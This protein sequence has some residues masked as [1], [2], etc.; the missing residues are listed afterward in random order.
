MRYMPLVEPDSPAL[1]VPGELH[2]RA[3]MRVTRAA[4]ARRTCKFGSRTFPARPVPGERGVLLVKVR[5]SRLAVTGRV[6]F[7]HAR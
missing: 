6:T 5:E 3:T 4:A 7:C 1:L 2:F